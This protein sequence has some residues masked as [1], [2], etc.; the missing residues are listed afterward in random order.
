MFNKKFD[1]IFSL[2]D[3][4]ACTSYIRRFNLQNFS[5]P[6]D[7]VRGGSIRTR[8]EYLLNGFENFCLKENLEFF[9]KTEADHTETKCDFYRDKISGIEFLHDFKSG[10]PFDEEYSN[11]IDKYNRRISRLLD[12][13]NKSRRVLLIWLSNQTNLDL[14]DLQKCYK[15][16]STKFENKEIYMLILENNPEDKTTYLEDNHILIINYDNTSL[17]PDGRQTLMGNQKRNQEIFVKIKRHIPLKEKPKFMLFKFIKILI[18]II[19]NKNIRTNLR[20]SFDKNFYKA[21]L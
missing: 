12:E 4:C 8:V 5:Y 19:P 21:K 6:F 18:G 20:E 9:E 16:L 17:T 14:N 3:N 11:V 13:I 10:I 7:W 15:K 1:L 2:G